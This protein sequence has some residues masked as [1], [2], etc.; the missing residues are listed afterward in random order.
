MYNFQWFIAIVLISLPPA[1]AAQ[2]PASPPAETVRAALEKV[3]WLVGEWE[4]EGWQLRPDGTRDTFDVRETVRTELGG[5][6]ILIEGK[7]TATLPSGET[8]EGHH[9][10]GVFSYDA[11]ARQYHFDA[12]VKDGYQTRGTPVIEEN[13]Y[14]WSHPA[15]PD[16]EM[17]YTVQL[18][19]NGQWHETGSYCRAD[20]CSQTFEMR[21]SRIEA[22][23]VD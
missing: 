19:E 4:G 20:Q 7:G 11:F 18:D 5:V 2:S 14:H 10:I 22:G 3:G 1:V 17:R 15:G 9:A 21:L 8:V 13:R 6:L 23:E 12:F 16:A